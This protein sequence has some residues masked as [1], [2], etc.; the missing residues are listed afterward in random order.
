[1][2]SDYVHG[3]EAA[4]G[5]RLGDQA[6]TLEELLHSD[7]AYP[8]GSRVLEVGCGVGA[9]TVALARRSPLAE[10]TAVDIAP[11][12]LAAAREATAG[13]ANVRF[14]QA[15]AGRL[16]FADR[17][18]DHAFVC[19]LLEHL[20]R[21]AA[22]LAEI[23]RVLRPGGTLTAI[24]GDHGSVLF[25]PESPAARDAIRAQVDLQR[26]A[27]GDPMIGRRLHPLLHA[28]GLTEISVSPR[29][30][31]VD[32][33]R[34][35]LGDRFV[36]RT[37]TAMVAGVRERAL[38]AGL[39]DADRFDAGIADLLRAAAPDGT[40]SYTFFKAVARRP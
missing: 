14:R 9:Q 23:L 26:A 29:L 7:T 17:S 6:R 27:G 18:F 39:V 34:P 31:Y 37:F 13:F 21:P 38:A 25:H 35:D 33:A 8:P 2:G 1:M 24:E 4:E 40:F 19:F 11:A 20:P 28:A 22:A 32:G 10:F 16:P 3:Y 15:D 36:R 5:T 12:S 30:F